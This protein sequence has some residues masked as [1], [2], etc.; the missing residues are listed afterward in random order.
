MVTRFLRISGHW[1]LWVVTSRST[2]GR[3]TAGT[4]PLPLPA[5]RFLQLS[6]LLSVDRFFA[7]MLDQHIIN[8]GA[9]L[10]AL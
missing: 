1:E 3:S 10:A 7:E 8:H 6:R 4:G 9:I 5:V 2:D